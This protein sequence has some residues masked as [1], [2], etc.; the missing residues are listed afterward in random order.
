MAAIGSTTS[1]LSTAPTSGVY[2]AATTTAQSATQQLGSQDIFLKLLVAQMKY[3]DP[4]KPQ[5]PTAQTTQLAQFNMVD[6]QN[7]S[8]TLLAD[9]KAALAG[10]DQT[11]QMI[12]YLG[13]QVL[14]EG[15][16][17][18]YDGL[19][20]KSVSV[21][22]PSGISQSVI[23]VV[24]QFGN[25]VKT[26][27]SGVT[28][29]GQMDLTWD[30][31]NDRGGKENPGAYNIVVEG[32]TAYGDPVTPTTYITGSVN[33]IRTTLNGQEMMVDNQPIALANIKQVK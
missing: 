4:M 10:T 21:D 25:V 23:S 30:G 12:P 32:T 24:N 16:Q 27:H 8:N 3:Q 1:A 9:L 5:D 15:N 28:P 7:K 6:A 26:L 13:H 2:T 33:A 17:I 18:N 31:T 11:S 29:Q 19:A 14:Y 20:N 22:F